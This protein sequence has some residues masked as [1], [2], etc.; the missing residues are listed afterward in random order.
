MHQTL[1]ELLVLDHIEFFSNLLI[2]LRLGREGCL[3]R[4]ASPGTDTSH[5][6]SP[7]KMQ[8]PVRFSGTRLGGAGDR[9]HT[10][11]THTL[12]LRSRSRW[13]TLYRCQQGAAQP[14]ARSGGLPLGR[15]NGRYALRERT[16]GERARCGVPAPGFAR[17]RHPTPRFPL[18]TF[19]FP[20]E[21]PVL[22]PTRGSPSNDEFVC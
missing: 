18:L 1:G 14:A 21:E 20:G 22:N 5:L 2:K 10:P 11:P 19:S 12:S 17:R 7:W 6:A 9:P 4:R 13:T 8:W 15:G 16:G 3:W